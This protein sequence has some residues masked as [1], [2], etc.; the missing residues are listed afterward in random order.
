MPVLLRSLWLLFL[1]PLFAHAELGGTAASIEADRARMKA[2]VRAQPGASYTVH[3]IRD[4]GGL[5]V[6]EY[7]SVS[8][9]VFAV[10]WNGPRIPDLRQLLGSYFPTLQSAAQEH[11]GRHGPLHVQRPDLVVTSS[12]HQRAFA[13][14]AYAPALVP[15][16]VSP[17]SLR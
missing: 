16:G 5:V 3:E 4:P 12:G 11:P 14:F 15:A 7:L 17:E 6:R 10:G 2:V 8:G 9:H 1:L 13:G